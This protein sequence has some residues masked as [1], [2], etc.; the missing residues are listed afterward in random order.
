MRA[1]LAILVGFIATSALSLFMLG[2]TMMLYPEMGSKIA[3][4]VVRQYL[5][6]NTEQRLV[7]SVNAYRRQRGLRPLQ[8]DP[9]LMSTARGRTNSTTARNSRHHVNGQWPWEAAKSHGYRG[10]ATE[11]LAWGYP[12]PES[13]VGQPNGPRGG[14]QTSPGHARAMR[15]NFSEIGVGVRGSTYV[16]MF[17]RPSSSGGRS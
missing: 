10:Y 9:V 16:A 11:N 3:P 1:L 7:D 8:V 17:G 6:S 4:S 15:G 13:A 12:S 5:L 2:C 14:W